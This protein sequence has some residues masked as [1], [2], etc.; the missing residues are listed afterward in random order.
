M[1]AMSELFGRISFLPSFLP[2]RDLDRDPVPPTRRPAPVAA[3][4][5]AERFL[6][7]ARRPI[8]L[9]PIEWDGDGPAATAEPA[10]DGAIDPHRFDSR[11][12]RIRDRY[13]GARFSG[14]V[15]S[16]NDLAS[17]PN[18]VKIARL[19]F[20]EGEAEASQELL[21]LAL[22]QHPSEELRLAAIELAFLAR[23]A[24]RLV[25]LARDFRAAHPQA[26]AWEE[27]V[28]LGRALAPAESLFG[29]T[30]V[31]RDHEHYGPWPHL[32]N[33]IQAPWDLTAECA[34]ADFHRAMRAA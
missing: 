20:E 16:G 15:R 1:P 32:P 11:R 30:S 21:E 13:I 8:E 34:A 2:A 27:I 25:T 29:G 22:Q 5:E 12:A 9:D 7:A 24:E 18:V 23:D 28:R 31:A 17:A 4:S 3:D 26:A 6:A 33:W 10:R 14:M 19:L